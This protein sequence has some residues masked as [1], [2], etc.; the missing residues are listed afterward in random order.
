MTKPIPEPDAPDR[1]ETGG[2]RRLKLLTA[3]GGALAAY[4]AIVLMVGI[5]EPAWVLGGM[6]A[7]IGA[8]AS[9]RGMWRFRR[10]AL[11]L[12]WALAAAAFAVGCY[13]AHFAWTFWLFQEP[14]VWDRVRAVL[15]PLILLWLGG[16]LAWLVY[17]TRPAVTARFGRR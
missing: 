14:T 12:S 8:G 4:A 3:S 2:T 7:L 6:L 15:N 17:F 1:D 10:W 9:V 5:R 11:R 16:P 13:W